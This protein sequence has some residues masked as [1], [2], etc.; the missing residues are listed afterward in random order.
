MNNPPEMSTSPRVSRLVPAS[1]FVAPACGLKENSRR[2]PCARAA[3][4]CPDTGSRAGRDAG[5]PRAVGPFSFAPQRLDA[6]I[7][8]SGIQFGI[9]PFLAVPPQ[10]Y[11]TG[12]QFQM[13]PGVSVIPAGITPSSS[14]APRSTAVARPSHGRN[15]PGTCPP[16]AW[17]RDAGRRGTG[18]Q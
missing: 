13:P 15:G 8:P 11:G 14:A 3:A 1:R 16:T 9:S 10:T 4:G 12:V 7:N 6:S 5:R 17:A 18:A 2:I